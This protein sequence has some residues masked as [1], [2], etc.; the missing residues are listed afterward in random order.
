M[1]ERKQYPPS[2]PDRTRDLI[3]LW[4]GPGDSHHELPKVVDFIDSRQVQG[5]PIAESETSPQFDEF[6]KAKELTPTTSG[7]GYEYVVH[8]PAY[9]EAQVG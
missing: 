7:L 4:V 8:E 6:L 5:D 3:S 1:P 9:L 2:R